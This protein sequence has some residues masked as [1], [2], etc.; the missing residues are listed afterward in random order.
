MRRFFT[1]ALTLL[2]AASVAF[3]Q[4]SIKVQT[5]KMVA[6]G[7]QFD[8]TVTVSGASSSEEP[9]WNPGNGFQIVWGPQ[10]VGTSTS[11]S[12]INGKRTSSVDYT[13]KYILVAK[14][15][16]VFTLPP[17]ECQI[18]EEHCTS[19]SLR[20]EVAIDSGSS[21]SGSQ[22]STTDPAVTGKEKFS[23][24][25][26]RFSINKN[27]VVVGEPVKA[28]LK[29][30]T[31]TDVV[32]FEGAKFPTF[33]GFWSQETYAPQNVEFQRE[34]VGGKM[35]LSAVLREYTLIPQQTGKVTIEPAEIV[36]VMQ[37]RVSNP[38][39][40][41]F[42]ALFDEYQTVRRKAVSAGY[43]VNV[44]ALPE[45][46]PESFGGGVGKFSITAEAPAEGL[47]THEASSI[48]LT[49]SGSGNIAMVEAPKLKL[50]SDFEVYD[51]KVTENLDPSRLS[52]SKTFEYPF[53]PRSSGDFTIGPIEYSYY[54]N[55]EDKYATASAGTI[56]ISVAKGNA[57]DGNVSSGL[58]SVS[59]KEVKD[60][61]EDIR[62]ISMNNPGL[63]VKGHFFAGSVL[64]F[65]LLG[66]MVCLGLAALVV[67]KKSLALR[68]NVALTKNRAATKM[69]RKRLVVADQ[70][71]KKNLYAAFYEELHKAMLGFAADKLM[72]DATQLSKENIE[73]GF[74]ERG[75]NAES[76]ARFTEM[77][78]ACEYARY[79]PDQ[80]NEKMTAEYASAIEVISAIDSDMREKKKKPV[81]AAATVLLCLMTLS[82]V[83]QQPAR[84]E[85]DCDSLWISGVEAYS[86]GK[87]Q[88]A[89]DAWTSI[90]KSGVES[91]ELYCNIGDAYF[92]LNRT[93]YAIL[94]FERALKLNPSNSDARHNLAFANAGITDK[95][96]Q[97]PDFFVKKWASSVSRMFSS[98]VW[99]VLSVIFLAIAMAAVL[100]FLLGGRSSLKK[101]GF[102]VGI[103]ALLLFSVSL[104]S[105]LGQKNSYFREDAAIV[106]EGACPAKSSPA[107]TGASDLFVIHEGTRVKVLDTVGDWKNIEIPDGRRGW[108]E[109]KNIQII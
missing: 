46:A 2:C 1:I 76:A 24:A 32:G 104:A 27:K 38:G 6:Q 20:I 81:S 85:A 48:K 103:A 66:L 43:A 59:K 23:D 37:V 82:A 87:H 28:V 70:L 54:D 74:L 52:G 53:I 92:R 96:E 73:D 57:K 55:Q 4:G 64:H 7:E 26:L 49:V 36:C 25:F 99:A 29:L 101:T 40:S 86:E 11:V 44:S 58:Q 15:K 77:L 12:I 71:L 14:E 108:V 94:Y 61:G 41:I 91:S 45:G 22:N 83:S 18:D 79:S 60:L 100:L 30:Y 35:Y 50:P 78:D 63:S 19:N 17:V 34:N 65:V 68:S 62:Y 90:E 89:L 33:N 42:D 56:Q 107:E 95:F 105:S 47:K 3:A 51:V 97:I 88:E 75:V 98:D 93:G 102:S 106:V 67:L 13:Y 39:G 10:R 69:A 80:G 9:K 8:V 21:L 16:G 109:Y 5:K 72:M 84:A 31:R